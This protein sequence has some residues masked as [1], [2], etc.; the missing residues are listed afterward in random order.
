MRP[1]PSTLQPP[2]FRHIP[3]PNMKYL[4]KHVAEVNEIS[5]AARDAAVANAA[6]LKDWAHQ[7]VATFEPL[8]LRVPGMAAE[9]GDVTPD[10]RLF[11]PGRQVRVQ[12]RQWAADG[13]LVVPDYQEMGLQAIPYIEGL[14]A[15]GWTAPDAGT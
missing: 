12:A 9:Y 10:L 7:V 14:V 2:G 4:R 1:K 11:L 5:E 15:Q 13:R 3:L 6:G 8:V